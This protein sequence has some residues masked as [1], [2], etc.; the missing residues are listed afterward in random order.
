VVSLKRDEN[1]ACFRAVD[2]GG[3]SRILAMSMGCEMQDEC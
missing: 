2:K 3:E 1:G